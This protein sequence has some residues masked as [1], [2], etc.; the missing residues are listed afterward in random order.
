INVVA[1]SL[2]EARLSPIGRQL[3]ITHL[4]DAVAAFWAWWVFRLIFDP[5]QSIRCERRQACR[6][7]RTCARQRSRVALAEGLQVNELSDNYRNRQATQKMRG[8]LRHV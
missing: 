1:A 3:Q 7:A 2:C 6:C 8:P 4:R 5:T